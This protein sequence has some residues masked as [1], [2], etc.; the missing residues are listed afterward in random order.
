MLHGDDKNNITSLNL[1]SNNNNKEDYSDVDFNFK[2]TPRYSQGFCQ[3]FECINK[4]Y[5]NFTEYINELIKKEDLFY[6]KK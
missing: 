1:S 6:I 4:R 2:L 3:Y 5:L